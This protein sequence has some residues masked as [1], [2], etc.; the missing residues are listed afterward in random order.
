MT[1]LPARG[2]VGMRVSCSEKQDGRGESRKVE[3]DPGYSLT[4]S[5]CL[6]DLGL[7]P[8]PGGPSPGGLGPEPSG[9]VSPPQL[10]L[11]QGKEV[12]MLGRRARTEV[13]RSGRWQQMAEPRGPFC[14]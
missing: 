6:G 10:P 14:W 9:P 2:R 3:E 4:V 7:G 12:H 1:L 13:G 5:L 8:N 11:T